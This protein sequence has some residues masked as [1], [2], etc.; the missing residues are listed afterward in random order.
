LTQFQIV[1][2]PTVRV[3]HSYF[4]LTPDK[5]HGPNLTAN[6]HHVN[7]QFRAP[8]PNPPWLPDFELYRHLG[9][10]G[11]VLFIINAFAPRIIG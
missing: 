7:R 11:C 9:G 4:G 3:E 10:F 2:W 1:P 6:Q 5:N 8:C